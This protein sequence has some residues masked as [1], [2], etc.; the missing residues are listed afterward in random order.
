MNEEIAFVKTKMYERIKNKLEMVH[1]YLWK[2]A[3]P[4]HHQILAV[5]KALQEDI[6]YESYG[7]EREDIERKIKEE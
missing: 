2:E 4:N 5:V 1:F 3:T 7:Y 6:I